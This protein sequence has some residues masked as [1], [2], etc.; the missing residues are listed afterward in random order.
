M[1]SA[2]LLP[3]EILAA[4]AGA[5]LQPDAMQH[6]SPFCNTPLSC[7]TPQ[8]ATQAAVS[9]AGFSLATMSAAAAISHPQPGMAPAK[10]P[11]LPLLIPSLHSFRHRFALQCIIIQT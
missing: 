4:P 7:E 2:V 1:Q 5:A 11:T 8:H 3:I 10:G 9:S 6:R